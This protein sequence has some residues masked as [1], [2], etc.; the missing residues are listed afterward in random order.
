MS[1]A[2][3]D[4]TLDAFLAQVYGLSTARLILLLATRH[5]LAEIVNSGYDPGEP[6]TWLP[7]VVTEERMAD[8][9]AILVE[10]LDRRL[11]QTRVLRTESSGSSDS[12]GFGGEF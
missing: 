8:L 4:K 10:V 3:W 7:E 12:S 11:P 5:G 1:T 6:S 9:I 2:D